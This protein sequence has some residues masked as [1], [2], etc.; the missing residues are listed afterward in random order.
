MTSEETNIEKIEK[1]KSS[2]SWVPSLYFAEGFAYSIVVL[3]S[4]IMYKRMGISNADIA[5]YTSWLYLPWVIK[6]FW[7]PLVDVLRT[8]RYWILVMQLLI[9]GGLAGVGLTIPM[10]DF[11]Q[12]TLIFFWILAFAASTHEIAA[13]GFYLLGLRESRQSYFIGFRSSFFRIAIIVGQGLIVV[14]AGQLESTLSVSPTEFRV[15]ANPNKFFEETIKVDSVK[16]KELSG[17]LRV[18]AKPSYVEISTRPKTKEQV[19][20]Y[21]HFAKSFNIMNGFSREMLEFPDT[22][23]MQDLVGN[24][25]IVKFVLSKKPS[26]GSEYFINV[27]FLEGNEGIKVVEGKELRFT[28]KNWNK[29]AFAVIQ[30][31][32]TIAKKTISEFTARSQRIP[33]AWTITFFILA[34]LFILLFVYHRLVLPEPD[35]DKP[36]GNKR[37]SSSGKEF[38]RS[39]ARFFEKKKIILI[40]VFLLFYNFGE[41][42][43]VKL[44][45]PFMLDSRELGGLGLSTSEVGLINGIISA[46]ALML[47]GILGG[48]LVFRKGLK[49]LM[50]PMLIALNAPN[51]V[52]VY[53]AWFQPELIWITYACVAVESFGYGFGLTFLLMYMINVSDGEYRTSHYALASGFMALGMMI[54]G[55]L[56]GIIQEAIGYKFFFIWVLVA[57][58]PGFIL[59]KY[60]PLEYQ[61]GK[62]KLTEK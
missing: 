33:F 19:G 20:F 53:L 7:A 26:E 40:I 17:M 54:P 57:A 24:V 34:G 45:T 10:P 29:P 3:L 2:W 5:F 58:I 51:L 55:M 13:D 42:Q 35:E 37:T 27:D 22:T 41:A 39:F 46:I 47:G 60:I 56:S 8:K 11:F 44:S 48:I 43:L 61:F 30:L 52:Y 38:F 23:G 15:V 25:G 36:A 32:S 9:G 1:T 59:A 21:K 62:K 14:F 31:D 28:D 6:P 50:M 12:F 49:S 16:A 18:I 4:V